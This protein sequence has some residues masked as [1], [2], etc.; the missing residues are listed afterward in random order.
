MEGDYWRRVLK[1]AWSTTLNLFGWSWQKTI[2][3]AVVLVGLLHGLC[4]R[5][6]RHP[7]RLLDGNRDGLGTVALPSHRPRRWS[8]AT[9]LRVC[10]TNGYEQEHP[11]QTY[12]C[13]LR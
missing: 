3:G 4:L 1:R 12:C 7:A 9:H 2:G 5:P 10:R 8:A 6:R 13:H 11:H